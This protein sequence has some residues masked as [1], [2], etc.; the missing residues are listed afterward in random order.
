MKKQTL[1]MMEQSRKASEREKIALQQA[2]EAM[3][4]KD[5]AMLEAE[6]ATTRENSMLE[7]MSEA[8][9]D[10]L[11]ML[12]PTSHCLFFVLL[13]LP[14]NFLLCRLIGS[15]LD[16]AAEDQRVNER[17]NLLVNLSLN[18]GCLFWATPER[19]QQIVR[20][21][22]RACQVREFLNFCTRTLTLV[23]KTLFPRDEAPKTLPLLL[24]KF[25]D[26][27]RIHNFVRAQLTAGAR[28]AMIMI[29]IC[30][31]KLDL[32]KI[33]ADCLAKKSRRK[34]DI[35]T[36]NEMVTPVAESM[37]DE[38]LR[39]DSEFFV[40]GTYAEHKTTRGLSIDSILGLD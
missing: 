16:A 10:M 5:A 21:Q 25:R 33:V 15:V 37:M 28:F 32:T 3:A 11:G 35:D 38:L 26:A 14:L 40:K 7:L 39:M 23:Y 17:T 34:N 9:T 8:S 2:K 30:H 6:K 20:F 31:P 24:E 4:A 29:N 19:T 18:H 13:C 27:P 22:D 36:I 1:A 12:F